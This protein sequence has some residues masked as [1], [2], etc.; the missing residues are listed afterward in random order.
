MHTLSIKRANTWDDD[1][2]LFD[3]KADRVNRMLEVGQ[4]MLREAGYGPYYIYRQK[5]TLSNGENIGYAKS[6][7]IGL[8]NIYMMEDVHTVI[9]CGAGASTK[10]FDPITGRIERIYNM[11]HP[12]D[13]LQNP[14]KL[15]DNFKALA[16]FLKGTA[17]G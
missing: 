17:D 7:H 1:S 11:K 9:G 2:T 10:T 16:A 8:Y 4:D 5:S 13:Y 12:L 14:N 6:G 15:T 3:P